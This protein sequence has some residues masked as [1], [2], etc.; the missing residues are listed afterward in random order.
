MKPR[1]D[2][3]ADDPIMGPPLTVG[4]FEKDSRPQGDHNVRRGLEPERG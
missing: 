3:A 1:A 2:R 4:K